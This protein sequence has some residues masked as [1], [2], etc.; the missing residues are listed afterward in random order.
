MKE[1][2]ED[3]PEFEEAVARFVAFARGQGICE[4]VVFVCSGDV[5]MTQGR[6]HVRLPDPDR[7]RQCAKRLYEAAAARRRGV[8]IGG[9]CVVDCHFCAYVYGPVDDDEASRLMVPDG[10][11]LTIPCSLPDAEAVRGLRWWLAKVSERLWPSRKAWTF[12]FTRNDHAGLIAAP[13]GS[14]VCGVPRETANGWQATMNLNERLRVSAE[15]WGADLFGVADLAAAREAILAQGGPE[16]A[17][18]PRAVSVGIVLPHAIVDRLPERPNRA[19]AASYRHHGYEVINQRLDY[20]T[21]RIASLLQR[22]GYRAL[23]VAASQ[24]VDDERLCAVFSH[25]IA[26]HLAGLGWIGKS[27]LVVTREAGPRVRWGTVLTDAPLEAAGE[28][29]QSRCGDCGQCV[30]ICPVQAFSGVAFCASEAREKR[31]DA[32]KCERY[33]AAL[34][35]KEG[36]KAAC[37]LCLYVCP[38]GRR[39][40][41]Q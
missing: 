16:V 32:R 27:C 3:Y 20:I 33:F 37:G 36:Q 10:V 22:E 17:A 5:A 19:V 21:S 18:Y 35:E 39:G 40:D 9:L 12:P 6:I 14:I 15:T 7:S 26:A 31:Y 29:M 2:V 1:G 4:S 41:V 30:E 11:K 24:R 25:K 13:Q 34:D 23:P 38:W 8:I 28:P